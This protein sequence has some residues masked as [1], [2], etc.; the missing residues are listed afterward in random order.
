MCEYC[1]KG[2]NISLF[3]EEF[4]NTFI[5][6]GHIGYTLI[7]SK[8]GLANVIGYIKYCPMCGRKLGGQ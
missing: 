7:H 2:K 6:K 5:S 8:N 4:I 1:E 3:D